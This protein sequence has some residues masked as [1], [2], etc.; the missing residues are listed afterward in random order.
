MEENTHIY[1]GPLTKEKLEEYLLEIFQQR[2][3]KEN[4]RCEIKDHGNN[5]LTVTTPIG[6]MNCNKQMWEDIMKEEVN[7]WKQK[8]KR[9]KNWR[10]NPNVYIVK[11]D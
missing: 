3:A 5:R 10:D 8:R 1:N 2:E 4:V 11:E 7:S 6:V 9:I